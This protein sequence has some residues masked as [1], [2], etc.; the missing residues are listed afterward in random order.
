M[1][2]AMAQPWFGFSEVF[3]FANPENAAS[4][5]VVT[6][7]GFSFHQYEQLYGSEFPVWKVKTAEHVN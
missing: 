5:R 4:W 6:K 3:A 1:W 2:L 7:L